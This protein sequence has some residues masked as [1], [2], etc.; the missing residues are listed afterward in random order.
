M[1]ERGQSEEIET[2]K[3]AN[4]RTLGILSCRVDPIE[5]IRDIPDLL[6]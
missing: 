3:W 1:L 4:Y 2:G 6:C 5:W